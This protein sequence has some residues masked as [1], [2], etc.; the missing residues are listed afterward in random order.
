MKSLTTFI[1][2]CIA[3]CLRTSSASVFL[4]RSAVLADSSYRLQQQPS[5]WSLTNQ[6]RKE[7]RLNL[8]RAKRTGSTTAMAIPGYGVAEQVFVGTFTGSVYH[9]RVCI[10]RKKALTPLISHQPW[11]SFSCCRRV[12]QLSVA[13]QS[14]NYG[15]RSPVVVPPS[16]R[17][18][19]ASAS[20]CCH[21]SILEF[22]PRN[23]SSHFR[24]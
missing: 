15:S 11:I 9:G 2:V 6:Q 4:P 22:I 24:I 18:C 5:S 3:C 1:A 14:H 17:D 12:F 20:L 23:N 21:G 13:L 7:L 16:S 10:D 8:Y 19:G